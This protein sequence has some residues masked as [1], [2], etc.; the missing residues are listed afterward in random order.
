M[1]LQSNLGYSFLKTRVYYIVRMART[2]SPI[3]FC[4]QLSR[5]QEEIVDNKLSGIVALPIR[6]F[7][8]ARGKVMETKRKQ[9][10]PLQ[11]IEMQSGITKT[12]ESRQSSMLCVKVDDVL[13]NF[14]NDVFD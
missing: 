10:S 5:N 12:E 4:C 13:L 11:M 3:K 9:M 14:T 2:S 7:Y 8:R 6:N 1:N